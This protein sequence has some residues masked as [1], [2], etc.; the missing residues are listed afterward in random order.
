MLLFFKY[1]GYP[2]ALSRGWG[3][4]AYIRLMKL[5]NAFDNGQTQPATVVFFTCRPVET[6]KDALVFRFRNARSVVGNGK[7][8]AFTFIRYSDLYL[9]SCG[10]VTDSIID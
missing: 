10:S 9:A 3:A 4:E 1:Q 2:Q 7:S 5:C 6:V 8:K